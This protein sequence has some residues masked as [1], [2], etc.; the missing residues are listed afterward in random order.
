MD[1]VAKFSSIICLERQ[2]CDPIMFKGEVACVKLKSFSDR[3]QGTPPPF[4]GNFVH[5][6]KARVSFHSI[7]CRSNNH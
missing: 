3:S 4:G 7:V 5:K 6:H 2:D 1:I